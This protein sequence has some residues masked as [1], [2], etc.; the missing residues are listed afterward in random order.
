M[1]LFYLS[2]DVVVVVAILFILVLVCDP[3]IPVLEIEY[4]GYRGIRTKDIWEDQ[5]N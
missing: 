5:K 1:L 3:S 4:C 2:T